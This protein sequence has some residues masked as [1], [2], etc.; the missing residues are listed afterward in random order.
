MILLA[1]QENMEPTVR[2]FSIPLSVEMAPTSTI[3]IYHVG[4]YGEVSADSLTFPV[5]GISRNNVSIISIT[6]LCC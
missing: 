6:I 5:N 4:R 1:G 3:I 2:T